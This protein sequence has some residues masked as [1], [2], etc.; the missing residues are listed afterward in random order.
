MASKEFEYPDQHGTVHA[1]SKADDETKYRSVMA[2]FS[3]ARKLQSRATAFAPERQ[4]NDVK[5]FTTGETY[6]ADVC[7]AIKAATTSVFIIGW[8]VNWAVKLQGE[9]RLIDALKAAVD[10]GAK[11]YVMPWQSPKVGLDTG[12]FSTMLAV[13]QLNAGLKKPR[14]FCC[15]AGMQNDYQS[16]EETFFS[17]HQKLVVVDNRIAYVGG[18]DLAFG[19]RDDEKFSLSHGWRTGPEIYNAIPAQHKLL[20][21]EAMAYVTDTELLRTTL[22]LGIANDSAQAQQSL[23]RKVAEGPVGRAYDGVQAWW[24]EPTALT[25]WLRN[26]ATEAAAPIMTRIERARQTVADDIIKP[27]EAGEL[28]QPQHLA[29]AIGLAGDTIQT[30]Y[31]TLL[32]ASWLTAKPNRAVMTPGTQSLPSGEAVHRA[33]QPRMPWQDVHARIEGPSVF[34]LCSNF[35]RRW[36]SLQKRY[37]PDLLAQITRID[38]AMK[39]TLPANGQG[40]GGSGKVMVR[41]LRSASVTLQRDEYEADKSLPA[42]QEEQHEIHDTMVS[43]IRG[44]ERFIYIE[45][46]FFQS[47]FGEPSVAADDSATASGPLKYMLASE[48]NRIKSAVTRA[49]A[50]N[51]NNGPKNQISRAIGDR[52]EDA[53]RKEQPFH[54]YMV[55]PV[56]PEGR[57]D[58]LAIV[59]QI[60]WTMQSLVFGS[61]SLVN[62]IRLAIRAKQLCKQPR[63]EEAWLKAKATAMTWDPD[64]KA[65]DFDAN[66]QRKATR[67]YLT[68]LNL[69]TAEVVAGHVRT[70]Q[71]YVHSKLLIA[72][73]R[74]VILGSANIN[75]RSLAGGRD[76]ELAVCL[77]DLSQMDAPLDGKRSVK[78]RTLAH[79][80]R[81]DLWKKHFALQGA[82]GIVQAASGL[83]SMLDK[84]HDPVTWAAIQAVADTNLQ[85]YATAFPWT[86]KDKSS[87]WPAWPPTVVPAGPKD[88]SKEEKFKAYKRAQDI[89][90]PFVGQMPFSEEFWKSPPKSK[91]PSGI[92]GFICALPME[93]T[94]GQNNHPRMNMILLT[95]LMPPSSDRPHTALAAVEAPGTG[96]KT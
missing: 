80:L 22:A 23:M 43:V 61:E 40:N 42:A 14:A 73:D 82:N 1:V 91:A 76:S 84:P 34:D 70:E 46:Q 74:V 58:D 10:N 44:A 62:R 18:I 33:D 64:T 49:G 54:V 20:P 6:Y 16:T 2:R 47:E 77:T 13:F 21:A 11:V 68:L 38:G 55:L 28:L 29:A 59:G 26:T 39:P 19:R 31:V 36:N 25:E 48:G 79:R 86:P 72:D 96:P 9:T 15:P 24:R 8:Q 41:V 78:V 51:A 63:D 27:L 83:S 93:W 17:H 52:I 85:A 87:I 94:M 69:R 53:I 7:G 3:P 90:K 66:V 5:A 30:A 75:D 4:G 81:V 95:E 60:H 57:L 35:I 88:N 67:N 71:V 37:L 50:A 92:Q 65:F 45:N 12:D 89:G 56:H 32:G